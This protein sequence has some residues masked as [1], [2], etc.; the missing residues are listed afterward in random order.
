[1]P[2]T[3]LS[4]RVSSLSLRFTN[5]IHHEHSWI[6]KRW[7]VVKFKFVLLHFRRRIKVLMRKLKAFNSII[8][9]DS[10]KLRRSIL[11]SECRSHKQCL[12]GFW[13]NAQKVKNADMRCE[14][15]MI[16]IMNDTLRI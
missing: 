3:L 10:K 6:Q 11:Q 16:C 1:V 9:S 5:W 7:K 15:L 2:Q 14:K 13:T 8:V 12:M 4:G